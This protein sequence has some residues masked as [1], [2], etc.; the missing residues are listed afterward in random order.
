MDIKE[1]I[2][3]RGD[4][5]T[6]IVHLTR[7]F[8]EQDGKGNL[9]KIISD[10][11]IV[12]KN[13]YGCAVKKIEERNLNVNQF[14][15]QR[16][17]SFTETPLEY[18]NLLLSNID[19]R[20]INFESYGL[21]LTKVSARKRGGNPVW[22]VDITPGHTWLTEPINILIGQ[23]LDKG[24]FEGSNFSK[25]TPFIEQ[26]GSHKE[27]NEIK[28]RKEFWWEREWR[29]VGDF[30]LPPNFIGLCP[31]N[32]IGEFEALARDNA[33]K[34][35]FIDPKWGLEKIIAHLAGFLRDEVDVF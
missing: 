7:T 5:S 12:A 30:C 27:K 17:V 26:M 29:H 4:L 28:Y 34:A 35:R 15:S 9:K 20:E 24:E 3:R 22:Y 10:K 31:E 21:A 23:L 2:A 19:G 8:D 18:I 25:L 33:F 6:F 16:V 14:P 1:I 13:S 32:E 11:V